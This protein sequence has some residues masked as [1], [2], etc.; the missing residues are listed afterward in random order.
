MTSRPPWPC[1]PRVTGRRWCCASSRS[2]LTRRWAEV[3]G[4]RH[5]RYD[6]RGLTAFDQSVLRKALQIPRG[7]VRPY[8]WVAREIGH[9]AAVR[10]VGTALAN[11][12]TP[13]L[14]PCHRVIRADGVIG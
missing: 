6:R 11:N 3:T 7:Q 13:Y 4:K 8:N 9:P 2:L 5:L 10:A 1:C 14:I 12:P